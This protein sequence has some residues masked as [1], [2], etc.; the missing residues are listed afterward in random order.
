MMGRFLEAI[1]FHETTSGAYNE[2]G[3]PVRMP[4]IVYCQAARP[5]S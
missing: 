5:K 3:E 4:F 1:S 2:S